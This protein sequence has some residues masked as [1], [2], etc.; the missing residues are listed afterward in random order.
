M[1][2][3]MPHL[4]SLRRLLLLLLLLL[5]A[6]AQQAPR[7]DLA[8]IY[9]SASAAPDRTPVIVIP[10]LFGSKLRRADE[11]LWP[12]GLQRLLFS[13][14]PE[15]ALRIDAQTL[16]PQPDGIE[17]FDIADQVLGI[18]FYGPLIQTLARYGGYSPGRLGES[19]P[20]GVRRYYVFPYDWRQDNVSHAAALDRL[21]EQIRADHG[22]P[23]LR[24][25][26]VAHS[27]GGL[28]ARYYLRYGPEDVLDGA[29][30]LI[31]LYGAA[32]VRK[33]ILLGTPN[34]GAVSAL[35]GFLRGEPVGLGRIPP[36]LIASLPS[37]YQLFPHPLAHWLVDAQGQLLH[38]DLYDPQTWQRLGWGLWD[39]EVATRVRTRQGE[40][41]LDTLRRHFALRL[42]RARR[43][44]WM[45]STPEPHTPIRYVLFGG[46]C[47]STP[48]RVLLEPDASGRPQAR[49]HPAELQR[50]RPGLDYEELLREPGDGRVTKPSLLA[51]E[52]LDPSAAQ[53]EE[54]FL[55]IAYF[56][57]LCERHDQLTGNINFQD[58]LLN[59]LLTPRLP[60]EG[61]R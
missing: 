18:D 17:A 51:R 59:T 48:A 32:R 24:V 27:M 60:W 46:N 33:L 45:L 57:F 40:A 61:G 36:E 22:D 11:V 58:N 53:D 4:G 37:A 7:P 41:G 9:R 3:C 44:A 50:P 28:V 23:E 16:Q 20:Q 52:T 8:R 14:Y 12:G 35:H 19:V 25:D 13:D 49:L 38:D 21:I 42:E 5:A 31:T 34:F 43:L 6:C 15:L 29:P 56:F 47:E 10:G 54:A 1:M 26:L 30:K 2:G 55:P 39:E